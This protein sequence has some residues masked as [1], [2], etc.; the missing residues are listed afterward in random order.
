MY[1]SVALTLASALT[2]AALPQTP[3]PTASSDGYLN[4]AFSSAD[5]V[6]IDSIIDALNSYAV[7]TATPSGAVTRT[8]EGFVS[9]GT[10]YPTFTDIA[11]R[12]TSSAVQTV[13]IPDLD[14]EIVQ[15]INPIQSNSKREVVERGEL[16]MDVCPKPK[17][18]TVIEW[19]D[20]KA[21]P[22]ECDVCPTQQPCDCEQGYEWVVPVS[23][24]P[25]CTT[26]TDP[27]ST[28]TTDPCTTTSS[29]PC[30]TTTTACPT[31]PGGVEYIILAIIEPDNYKYKRPCSV[32][33]GGY[34]YIVADGSDCGLDL[35]YVIDTGGKNDYPP[36]QPTGGQGW[37]RALK[38]RATGEYVYSGTIVVSSS[39]QLVVSTAF[40]L[41]SD[42]SSVLYWDDATATPIANASATATGLIPIVRRCADLSH[43]QRNVCDTDT[44]FR[45]DAKERTDEI[46]VK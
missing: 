12:A 40:P 21:T 32:C 18:F 42:W 11:V 22:I 27:C 34:E 5:L 7:S 29:D 9:M 3:T 15:Y 46:Y 41:M 26:T 10:G 13:T 37:G 6:A 33:P 23:T 2:A 17:T 39:S 44:G 8:A 1:F 20:C 19:V 30:A 25:P 24:N 45:G 43:R 28:T 35:L 36:A 16:P 31:C 38:A 14:L 4:P